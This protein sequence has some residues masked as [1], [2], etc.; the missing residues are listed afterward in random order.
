MHSLCQCELKS[1]Q[2]A[3]MEYAKIRTCNMA[4]HELAISVS[5]QE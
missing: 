4:N 5:L 1:Q 3:L 2:G